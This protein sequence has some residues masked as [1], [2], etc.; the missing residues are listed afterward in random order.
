M[1]FWAVLDMPTFEDYIIFNVMHLT[2]ALHTEVF[3]IT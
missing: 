3:L 1:H 2:F